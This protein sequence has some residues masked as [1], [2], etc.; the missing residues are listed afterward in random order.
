[1]VSYTSA[2]EQAPP[3]SD[4]VSGPENPPSPE[5]VPGPEYLEYL[6]P[7]DDEVPIK[8]QPLPADGSPTALSPSYVAESDSEEDPEEDPADYPAD[9]GDEEEESSVDDADDEDE[10][11]ASEDDDDDEEEEE[12]LASAHPSTIPID[13]HVPSAQVI[14]PF[15]IDEYAPTPPSPRLRRARILVRPQTPMA[16]FTEALIA[17]VATAL[18][19][20]SPPPSLLTPL[21]SPLP[22]IP[23]PPPTHTRAAI[24]S[25]FYQATR[26]RART[27]LDQAKILSSPSSSP[28]ISSKPITSQAQAFNSSARALIKLFRALIYNKF[29]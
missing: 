2:P 11:E 12:H 6:V 4:Y 1:M 26:A 19:S 29:I 14:E 20:S 10:E 21:S 3:S 13:E 27:R 7:S 17:A 28:K 16:S 18:P 5:Y 23:S 25:S 8:D 9:G 15:E 22:Q 24:K